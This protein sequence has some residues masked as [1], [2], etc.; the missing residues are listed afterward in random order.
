MTTKRDLALALAGKGFHVFPLRVKG[1]KPAI[2]AWQKRATADEAQVHDWWTDPLD[3][4]PLD[5][6]IGICTTRFGADRALLAVD[7]DNKH[8]VK[9]EDTLMDLEL[10]G[11]D[12]PPTLEGVT[13]TGG[14]HL[15]Y[16]VPKPVNQRKAGFLGP[17]LDIRSRGGYIVAHGSETEKGLYRWKGGA[18]ATAPEWLVRKLGE[19]P[20]RVQREG[21]IEA[22]ADDRFAEERAEALIEAA[23][24]VAEGARND[25]CYRMAA[26]F[27]DLGMSEALNLD[28]TRDWNDRKCSP[29]IDEDELERTV[30]SVYRTA[31]SPQGSA[32]PE[33]EFE[34]TEPVKAPEPV[35]TDPDDPEQEKHPLKWLNGRYALVLAGGGHHILWETTDEKGEFR[36]EHL[37]ETA[38][39]RYHASKTMQIG[40]K[41][42]PITKVWMG[43]PHRRTYKGLVFRPEGCED[44]Q[45]Y[46]LWRGFR[47]S[48]SDQGISEKGRKAVG[49]WHEHVRENVCQ[50]DPGLYEWFLNYVAHMFQYPHV[51]PLT[52]L[53]LRGGKG[54]GKDSVM[55]RVGWLLGSHYLMTANRRYLVGNFN[56]HLERLLMFVLNEAFWSGDKAAEGQLKDLVTGN[57]HVIE[58]KGKEPYSVANLTR[59]VVIGNEEWIVPA[60]EDERRWAVFD[61]GDGRKKDAAFFTAMR[62]GIDNA[63]GA[64]LLLHQMLEHPVDTQLVNVAPATA[65]LADQ[66]LASLDPEGEWWH[67]CLYEGAVK[68]SEFDGWPEWIGTERLFHAFTRH[69]KERGIRAR[70]PNQV[71]FGRSFNRMC[72]SATR[73]RRTETP[74]QQ[75]AAYNLPTV[76]QARADF[77]THMGQKLPWR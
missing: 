12:F 40:E 7:I 45:W 19:A 35:K 50:G 5:A 14:R 41:N 68:G 65:G 55:D 2:T 33:A 17:G 53:V 30:R 38:F 20:E 76:E 48:P 47:V 56:A 72:A 39:H 54:V 70:L 10:E 27:R 71:H 32:R 44:D 28:Y 73:T 59:V 37:T 18:I 29:P 49:L 42:Q 77:E 63:D 34:P 11:Y 74:G 26:K 22:P 66:K 8:G 24:D 13:P 15:I 52:A 36:L 43:W 62:E 9:G 51:K 61:I 58:H 31:R 64:K 1:K 16:S 69:A 57:K 67:A 75:V 23:E 21:G 46:N 4:D 3:G 25:E 6:N 60:T